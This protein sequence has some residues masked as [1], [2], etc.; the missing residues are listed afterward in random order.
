MSNCFIAT[1][2][3]DEGLDVPTCTLVIR[4]NL[5]MDVRAYIQSKGRARFTS[6]RY[7]LLLPKND[8]TY[9]ERYKQYQMVE[10]Y[11]QQVFFVNNSYRHL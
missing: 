5:P 11:L 2:V 7:V 4:Y 1:D 8:M 6:S 3:I 10:Q 9:L